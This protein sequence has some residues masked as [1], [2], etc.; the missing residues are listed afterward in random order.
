VELPHVVFLLLLLLLLLFRAPFLPF[1]R[2]VEH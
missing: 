2:R 1:R